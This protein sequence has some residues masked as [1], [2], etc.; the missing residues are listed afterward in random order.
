VIET[1]RLLLRK[2]RVEDAEDLLRYV[3]DPEVTRWIGGEPG[4]RAATEAKIEDW[5]AR[6]DANGIGH[7]SVVRDGRVLGRCGFLTWDSRTWTVA[8]YA[9]AGEHA[10]TELGWTLAREHWGQG[11]ATEAARALRNWAYSERGIERLISLIS[12]RNVRSIRVADKLGA[13]PEKMVSNSFGATI[14]WVH[15][16]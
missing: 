6:W 13:E 3:G 16:R 8:S 12:P 7:F 9:E 15:P 1:E 11:Y 5:L 10:E 2:P 14:V 4:D